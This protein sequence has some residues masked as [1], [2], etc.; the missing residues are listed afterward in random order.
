MKI[1]TEIVYTWDDD[2]N[3][4]VEESSKSF[5]YEG[6]VTQCHTRKVPYTGVNIPHAHGGE[7]GK[8]TAEVTKTQEKATGWAKRNKMDKPGGEWGNFT[9][10][11]KRLSGKAELIA[12]GTNS[13]D[14]NSSSN[15]EQTPEELLYGSRRGIQGRGKTAKASDEEMRRSPYAMNNKTLLTQGQRAKKITGQA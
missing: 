7:M 10:W 3:E 12:W 14:D 6:E 8:V 15:G 5:D 2:K 4:L 1:Y 11:T 13:T 9:D